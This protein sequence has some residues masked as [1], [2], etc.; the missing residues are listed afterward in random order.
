MTQRSELHILRDIVRLCQRKDEV[1]ST[2]IMAFCNMS[3]SQL[4]KYL[5]LALN[6]G[7]IH[8]VNPFYMPTDKGIHFADSLDTLTLMVNYNEQE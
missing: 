6:S 8:R 4:E 3:Y 7:L 5:P 1:R 2:H